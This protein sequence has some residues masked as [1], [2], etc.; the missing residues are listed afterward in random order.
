MNVS[1][2]YFN[3]LHLLFQFELQNRMKIS[4]HTPPFERLR[5]SLLNIPTTSFNIIK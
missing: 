2:Y 4:S 5:I 3:I 1:L